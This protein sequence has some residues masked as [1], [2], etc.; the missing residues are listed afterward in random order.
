MSR[1][2]AL[3]VIASALI[4]GACSSEAT[5]ATTVPSTPTVP[6][7]P[8]S[9]WLTVQLTTPRSDDGAVQLSIGGPQIDSVKLVTY[10]GFDTNSGTQVDLVATGDVTGGAIAR[11]F[12]P[13]VSRAS[14]YYAS[15]S[16]AA[17]RDSYALQV[18]DGY[19]ATVVR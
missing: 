10:D 11:I 19:S 9:G 3:L 2:R 6:A 1:Y 15:V 14:Q 5:T 18:L 7:G 13:D 8:T 12:V 17:A 4:L 16:A